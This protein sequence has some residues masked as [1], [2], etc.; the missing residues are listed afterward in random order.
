MKFLVI[1]A[2]SSVLRGLQN[3]ESGKR[4]DPTL[5]LSDSRFVAKPVN[6]YHAALSQ[7]ANQGGNMPCGMEFP[8]VCKVVDND[9]VPARIATLL[10]LA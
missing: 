3:L 9:R 5:K 6:R 4:N 1:P 10:N 8:N 7:R 2:D